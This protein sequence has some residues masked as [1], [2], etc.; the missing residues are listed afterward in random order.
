MRPVEQFG[1]DLKY[2][3]NDNEMGA[4]RF[5]YKTFIKL[6]KTIPKKDRR[7]LTY[8]KHFKFIV[9]HYRKKRGR[10]IDAML[11]YGPWRLM[12]P[13]LDIE[14]GYTLLNVNQSLPERIYERNLQ[15]K[16]SAKEKTIVNINKQIACFEKDEYI[17]MFQKFTDEEKVDYT[18][19]FLNGI[20]YELAEQEN[21]D[22][23]TLGAVIMVGDSRKPINFREVIE[24]RCPLIGYFVVDYR[25]LKQLREPNDL[26]KWTE[27][28]KS[29]AIKIIKER[30]EESSL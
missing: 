7:N 21:I 11:L 20:I 29:K 8:M 16:S 4:N 30:K 13:S 19:N 18:L 28:A 17:K 24:T 22:V 12:N 15:L 23:E 25:E 3:M 26:L 9:D 2:R 27:K 1:V 5:A 14:D 10:R 6:L